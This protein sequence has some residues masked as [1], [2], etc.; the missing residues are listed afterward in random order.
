MRTLA[1]I[2]KQGTTTG[3][4]LPRTLRALDRLEARFRTGEVSVIAG[5][6]GAGKTALALHVAI[7]MGV[8]T[9]YISADS[10]DSTQMVRAIAMLTGVT[11]KEAEDQAAANPE[12]AADLL[13]HLN[14]WWGGDENGFDAAPSMATIAAEVRAFTM[15][16]GAPPELIIVDSLYNVDDGE[17]GSGS[18]WAGLM[19]TVSNLKRY[20]AESEAAVV[21]LHHT[22]EGKDL[23]EGEAPSLNA[24]QGKVGPLPA[25]V[26]T[27]ANDPANGLLRIASVKNRHGFADRSGLNPELV[28]FDPVRMGI[29]DLDDR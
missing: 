28:R 4:A 11:Q 21:V 27:L 25:L 1:R 18:M 3:K 16:M 17:D 2:A 14:I 8:S 13:R 26:L 20:A 29:R 19:K 12:W 5:P 23:A 9:L 15:V 7:S 6:P 22:N 10:G 24:L